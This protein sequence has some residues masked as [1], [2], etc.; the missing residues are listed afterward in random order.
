MRGE[1]NAAI[2]VAQLYQFPA[3]TPTIQGGNN[4]WSGFTSSIESTGLSVKEYTRIKADLDWQA[5]VKGYITKINMFK[6]QA[7]GVTGLQEFARMVTRATTP[8]LLHYLMEY[9]D[10]FISK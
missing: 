4:E 3:A 10:P 2:A 7:L 9:M 1:T 5:E 8:K 6:T